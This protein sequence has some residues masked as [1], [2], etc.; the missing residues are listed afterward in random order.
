ML[1]PEFWVSLFGLKPIG[2]VAGAPIWF[3][4]FRRSSPHFAEH[5]WLQ[6]RGRTQQQAAVVHR[7]LC[8]NVLMISEGGSREVI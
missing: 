8:E 2:G 5:V 3:L 7:M 6:H 4:A 1:Y